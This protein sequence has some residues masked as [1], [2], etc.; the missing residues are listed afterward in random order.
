M[1]NVEHELQAVY[2]RLITGSVL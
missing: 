2:C 1:K